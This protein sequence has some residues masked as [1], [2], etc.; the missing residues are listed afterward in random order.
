[1]KFRPRIGEKR[2][3]TAKQWRLGERMAG[4]RPSSVS[5]RCMEATTQ[6][7]PVWVRDRDW[8]VKDDGE[9]WVC[10][11]RVFRKLYEPVE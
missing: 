4:L 3:V 9:I 10:N 11:D 5:A 6:D 1:M 2:V 7:G 8:V